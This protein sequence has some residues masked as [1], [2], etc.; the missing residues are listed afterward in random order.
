MITTA[1]GF[2][3]LE[4]QDY[5]SAALSDPDS[6]FNANV[7]RVEEL[8]DEMATMQDNGLT[9]LQ[10]EMQVIKDATLNNMTN[11]VFVGSFEGLDSMRLTRGIFDPV[12]RKVYV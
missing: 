9:N 1:K 2:K 3:K 7:D 12:T 8:L 4:E 6:A 10:A 5:A 11:N